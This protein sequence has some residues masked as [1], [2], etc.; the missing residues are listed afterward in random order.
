MVV[1]TRNG[2]RR[3]WEYHNTL[4]TEGVPSPIVRG[5]AHDVTERKRAERALRLSEEKFATAFRASPTA[6]VITTLAEGRFLDV[7]E[8]FE[9]HSGF[10][11]AELCG[12]TAQEVGVWENPGEREEVMRQLQAQGSISNREVTLRTKSGDV[13]HGL[14]SAELLDLG[15]ERCVLAAGEDIT[16]RKQA[17]E[18]LRR[19]ETDYRSLVEQAPYGIVRS[20]G[21][22]RVLMANAALVKMLGYKS[23]AELRA[24]D[25]ARDVYVHAEDRARVVEECLS[26]ERFEGIELRW[27]RKDGTEIL[28]RVSGRPVRDER[29]QMAYFEVMVEDITERTRLEQRLSRARKLEAITLLATGF[30]HDFNQALSGILGYSERLVM[31]AGLAEPQRRDA[32]EILC[33][34]LQG[35][36]L[37]QHLLAFARRGPVLEPSVVNL[38]SVVNELEPMLR[39]LVGE[40]IELVTTL[41]P[42]PGGVEV[43]ARQVKQILMNLVAN[44]RDA[45][46][47]GGQLT[48][49]TANLDLSET[50]CA[51]FAGVD[52]G[53]YVML[54]V[55]D[56]GCGMDEAT[57]ARIFEPFFTTKA[58][59]K[60][61]GLG[62]FW[63]HG[64]ITQSGGEI[65]VSSCPG[66]GSTF[67]ILLPRKPLPRGDTE[68]S[69]S[70]RTKSREGSRPTILVVEDGD[71]ERKLVCEFL[72]PQ[73]K[74]LRACNATEGLKVAQQYP[75]EID[76]LVT[77]QLLPGMSG[78]DLVE[79]VARCRPAIKVLYMTGYSDFM[80]ASPGR[81]GPSAGVLEK[82]FLQSELLSK[83]EAAL[84]LAGPGCPVRENQPL[85]RV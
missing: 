81:L 50:R 18:A 73:Y 31:A 19:S 79:R 23:E 38:N 3:I 16:A 71:L 66:K 17:E 59:G 65:L 40:R 80:P 60:G 78:T 85:K 48:I 52:A 54:E 75:E 27:K 7:N 67:K 34:A 57:R 70:G 25:I 72:E 74:V 14:Y 9:R 58:H 41:E 43:D 12:R 63:V 49:Q 64:S 8:S 4:R 24:L 22:G 45:M 47:A 6:M 84:G 42:E 53:R 37:T 32:E 61:T 39:S 20:T 35:R 46:A 36:E 1:L 77:D 44:G 62:L 76:L 68:A 5:I 11:R 15:G 56:T 69:R 26:K 30:A 33:A 21:E 29:G 82:P 55:A 10:S 51:E 83:V 2:E 28:V 13:R